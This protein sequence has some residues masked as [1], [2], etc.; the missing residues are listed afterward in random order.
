MN[1]TWMMFLVSRKSEACYILML[2]ICSLFFCMYV[3]NGVSLVVLKQAWGVFMMNLRVPTRVHLGAHTGAVFGHVMYC[4]QQSYIYFKKSWFS[5]LYLVPLG[6]KTFHFQ[7][8]CSILFLLSWEDAQEWNLTIEEW[9]QLPDWFI[10]FWL[11]L[12]CV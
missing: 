12:W 9:S 8:M 1:Y 11:L 2:R 4:E 10:F 7:Q 3:R 6:R 5:C